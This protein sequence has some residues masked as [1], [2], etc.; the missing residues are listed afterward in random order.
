MSRNGSGTYSKV[1]TFVASATITAAGHNQNWD[2][3]AAEMTNSVAAD[4]QTTMTGPLKASSGTAAA[5]SHT[6][7]S[8][9][10]TGA[11]RIGA[12]NYGIAVGGAKV[13]DVATTGLDVTGTVNSSG[14]VKQAGFA[15][16]P[17]GCFFPYAGAAAPSGY[18]LCDGSA[19][20]RTTYA[21][22]FTAIGT[23]Y[24]VGDGSTTFNVPD[25]KGRV[26]AGKEASATR[27]TATHFGGDSTAL[28]ATGGSESHTLTRAQLPTGITSTGVT[29]NTITVTGPTTGG[30]MSRSISGGGSSEA[31]QAGS[32]NFNNTNNVQ[33]SGSNNI[34]ATVT[35]NNTSGDAHNIVQPTIITNFIIFAG[36]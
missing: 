13:L 31:Y 28:G 1:N 11:Y 14:A 21:T 36:V 30:V 9:P 4:G 7:G 20:S 8:D 22:L 17:V 16:L 24:G 19:V 26:A 32:T 18:L 2:D 33:M 23:A 10:D 27:L 25:M 12:N 3:L 35:S 15:L 29:N 5:P 6:F 34:T